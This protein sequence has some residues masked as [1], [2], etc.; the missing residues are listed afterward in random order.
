MADTLRTRLLGDKDVADTLRGV[1]Q[2]KLD[3]L[4]V[5]MKRG[6]LKQLSRTYI[7]DD[8]SRISVS[9]RFGSKEIVIESPKIGGVEEEKRELEKN[10]RWLQFVLAEWNTDHSVKSVTYFLYDPVDDKIIKDDKFVWQVAQYDIY[11]E[12]NNSSCY[13]DLDLT[14]HYP[15]RVYSSYDSYNLKHVIVSRFED[16]KRYIDSLSQY[17]RGRSGWLYFFKPCPIAPGYGSGSEPTNYEQKWNVI[18]QNQITVGL[19][20]LSRVTEYEMDDPENPGRKIWVIKNLEFSS[21][22]LSQASDIA[23]IT[24]RYWYARSTLDN[25]SNVILHTGNTCY[26]EAAVHLFD[27]PDHQYSSLYPPFVMD[28]DEEKFVS[29]FVV[30]WPPGEYITSGVDEIQLNITEVEEVPG[31]SIYT[32]TASYDFSAEWAHDVIY[33]FLQPSRFFTLVDT[34]AHLH[35]VYN[36]SFTDVLSVLYSESQAF[37]VNVGSEGSTSASGYAH[38]DTIKIELFCGE[39]TEELRTDQKWWSVKLTDGYTESDAA[40]LLVSGSTYQLSTTE[41]IRYSVERHSV[42]I[43]LTEAMVRTKNDDKLWYIGIRYRDN[44]FKLYE[45]V[46]PSNPYVFSDIT[47]KFKNA[48]SAAFGEEFPDN[49]F[50]CMTA[51]ASNLTYDVRTGRVIRRSTNV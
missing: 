24:E 23:Y 36:I 18:G 5:Q 33:R 13:S 11:A 29:R 47:Q 30:I 26:D 48:Y 22:R 9:N 40:M 43:V 16:K 27:Y 50:L 32:G 31:G 6:G 15:L 4:L 20:Y 21:D 12:L 25:F 37:T 41:N 49:R 39:A 34:G 19:Y 1:A 44:T 3:N 10:G 45:R 42:P 46:L 14:D 17:I 51:Y 28:L 7:G 38:E 35:T 2:Q 8:G